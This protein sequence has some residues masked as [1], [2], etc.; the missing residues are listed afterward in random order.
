MKTKKK[1]RELTNFA[2]LEDLMF[3]AVRVMPDDVV[4]HIKEYNGNLIHRYSFKY[5]AEPSVPGNGCLV[6]AGR[7]VHTVVM[8]KEK[9]I[10]NISFVSGETGEITGFIQHRPHTGWTD[11]DRFPITGLV[12]RVFKKKPITRKCACGT[13]LVNGKLKCM[14]AMGKTDAGTN[15]LKWLM[16]QPDEVVNK[17][18]E[19]PL[20]F[21][22]MHVEPDDDDDDDA[23]SDI[24]EDIR[25]PGIFKVKHHSASASEDCGCSS[26]GFNKFT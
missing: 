9:F 13:C 10:A 14:S 26:G 7:Y 3:L 17:F 22:K 4:P 21:M 12:W 25:V 24:D 23:D 2:D 18:T 20:D 6:I 15:I 8:N 1:M 19:S 5:P 11:A 16:A